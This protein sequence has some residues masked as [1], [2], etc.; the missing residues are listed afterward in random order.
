M[1]AK[2]LAFS[3]ILVYCLKAFTVGRNTETR[4]QSQMTNWLSKCKNLGIKFY[5]WCWFVVIHVKYASTVRKWNG[6][7]STYSFMRWW[8]SY[9]HLP[10]LWHVWCYSLS[11]NCILCHMK[12]EVNPWEMG[13]KIWNNLS[14]PTMVHGPAQRNI[15]E[16]R[17]E[18]RRSTGV[19]C[20]AGGTPTKRDSLQ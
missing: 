7:E 4:I 13:A 6:N 12:D 5:C 17:E 2:V 18:Q 1:L 15:H 11:I 14:S 8:Q 9:T 20:C 19:S 3:Y 10:I 16:K